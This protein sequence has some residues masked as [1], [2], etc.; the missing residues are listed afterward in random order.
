MSEQSELL[1]RSRVIRE[2]ESLLAS[3]R[4]VLLYGPEGIGKSAIVECVR[5]EG[6]VVVD[7]LQ[8]LSSQRA[9][10]IRRALDRGVPH[11]AASR[12][13]SGR[14]LGAV[15]RILWRFSTVRVRELPDAIIRRILVHEL[16]DVRCAPRREWFREVAELSQ[17]RPGFATS[18]GRL[19]AEWTRTHGDLPT[20]PFVY[21][22][23]REDDAIRALRAATK[24]Q[25]RLSLGGGR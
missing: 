24:I 13:P 2:V 17:G 22:A 3:G 20:P 19:A 9:S 23:V 1:G 12:V 15:G 8:R 25:G 7:P 5:R 11:V 16:Q 4:S 21:A 14:Q 18:M 10:R 6:V